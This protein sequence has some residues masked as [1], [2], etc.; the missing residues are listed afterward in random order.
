M[1]PLEISEHNNTLDDK[2]R[3]RYDI[4]L[5]GVEGEGDEGVQGE[6]GYSNQLFFFQKPQGEN[7]GLQTHVVYP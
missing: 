6:G 7:Y 5:P 3:E 4:A 1:K 2:L